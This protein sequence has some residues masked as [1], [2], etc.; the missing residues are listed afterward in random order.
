MQNLPGG[1]GKA[2]EAQVHC[3]LAMRV[4]YQVFEPKIRGEYSIASQLG[5]I[6]PPR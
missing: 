1:W 2:Q 6:L 3:A 5:G 4:E